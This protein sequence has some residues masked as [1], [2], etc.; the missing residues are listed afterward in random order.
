MDP[1][2]SQAHTMI[3]FPVLECITGIEILGYWWNLNIDSDP[4]EEGLVEVLEFLPIK[5]VSQKHKHIP[6]GT[7]EVSATTRDD[8][9]YHISIYFI[10]LVCAEVGRILKNE[11]GL[12]LNLIKWSP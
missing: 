3:I 9:I 6:R 11:C 7:S 5:I 10:W 4:R 2:G 12:L 1:A 8:V